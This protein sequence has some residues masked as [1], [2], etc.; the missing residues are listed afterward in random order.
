MAEA[1][2]KGLGRGLD[3]L[4]DSA[5]E[6]ALPDGDYQLEHLSIEKIVPGEYQPRQSMDQ[7]ALQE[8]ADSIKEQ[9]LLSP[10]IVRPQDK[11]RYEI[12]AGERRFVAAGLAGLTEVPVIIRQLD[13]KKTLALALIENLQRE[14][15]NPI[16]EALGID[17][18]VKE[19]DYT[20]EQAAQAI[21]RSRAATTNA[22]RLLNLAEEV[23]QMLRVGEIDMG[24]ARA[25]LTLMPVDQ[26]QVAKE[27]AAKGLNVRQTEALVRRLAEEK[28][29]KPQVVIKTRDDLRLEEALADTL[30]AKVSLSANKKGKGK[31][32]IEFANLE[33]LQG[34]VDKIQH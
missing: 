26:V 12:V 21:G 15:L 33:Q 24:H 5:E 3:A 18:L 4:F 10:I 7:G 32:I 30:G 31:I 16:D 9:G 25:L 27:V 6:I 11:D 2:K 34:I 29:I 8:L 20:H 14:G 23:Q 1:K 28:P 13:D 17:R 22:L 19:F